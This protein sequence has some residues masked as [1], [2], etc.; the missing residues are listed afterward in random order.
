[1]R[2]H[3]S[4]LL[5]AQRD[6]LPAAAVAA[7]E[8]ALD[9]LRG[10]IEQGAGKVAL[11]EQMGKLEQ[12]ANRWLRPY[13]HAAW[14][15]IIEVLLVALGV[16]MAIRTF[17]I[18]PFKIPTGSMQPTL[19]GITHENL[20]A[21]PDVKIPGRLARFGE[22]WCNGVSY[23]H[24]TAPADGRLQAVKSPV[25]FLLFNLKQEY[26]FAGAW[27]TIWFPVDDLFVRGGLVSRTGELADRAFRRGEDLF[28]LKVTAG[29]HLFVNR[30]KYNFVHPERGDIIVF[31]TKGITRLGEQN[32]YYIKRLVGLGGERLELR[33]DFEL[34]LK[35]RTEEVVIVP[36]GHLAVNGRDLSAST[37][38]F[39]E[40]YSFSHPPKDAKVLPYL[41]NHHYGHAM[42]EGLQPGGEHRIQPGHYYVLGDNTLNSSDSRYWGDFPRDLVIG[43]SSFI[44]WPISKRFG[45]GYR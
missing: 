12:T 31:K 14:R 16:A 18:Q 17:F 9:E 43:K 35:G 34:A 39:E 36:V 7:V 41:E 37:K 19:Y 40:L 32:T 11:Q 8:Q 27:Q 24:E 44:Y 2:Q 21:K 6:A 23:F 38:N 22:Y 29:D 25:K 4:K 13:P 15:E 20:G 33:R 10:T 45:F 3:V 1:M 26:L 30:V 42:L 5:A 28:K